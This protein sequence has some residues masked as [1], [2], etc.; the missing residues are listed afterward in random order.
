LRQNRSITPST[1]RE[2]TLV[3]NQAPQAPRRDD[4]LGEG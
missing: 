2:P 1:R 3:P 4:G